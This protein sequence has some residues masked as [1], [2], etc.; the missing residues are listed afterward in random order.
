MNKKINNLMQAEDVNSIS[1]AKKLLLDKETKYKNN[2]P[3]KWA[4]VGLG[5]AIG[6]CLGMWI[7]DI[8]NFATNTLF[9]RSGIESLL[10]DLIGGRNI[11]QSLFDDLLIVAYEYN[12]QTPRF[13]SKYFSK[14]DKGI[15]DIGM[16]LA[17]GGSSAVPGAFE[18]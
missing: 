7:P 9:D 13:Y 4:L 8:Y 5:L 6:A 15:F 2:K 1:K 12:S 14:Q 11:T 17:A 16:N 18:P 10:K 3:K